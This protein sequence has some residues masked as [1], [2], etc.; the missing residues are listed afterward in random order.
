M[1]LAPVRFDRFELQP[2]ERRLLADGQPVPLGARAFDLLCL[3]ASRPGSLLTKAELLDAVWAGLVVEEANLTV[4]IS[5]LRKV[6]GSDCIATVPGRGYRFT[7]AP[8][9]AAAPPPAT[10]PAHP[11]EPPAGAPTAAQA[12][13]PAL[14]GRTADRRRLLQALAAPGCVT[15]CGLAGV[16]KTALAQSVA[17]GWPTGAVWVDLAALPGGDQLPSALARALGLPTPEPGDAAGLLA[18]LAG[19]LLVLDNAEHLVEAVAAQVA[20]LLAAAPAGALLVTSQ[21]PL[22]LPQERVLRLEPLAC[23]GGPGAAEARDADGALDLFLAR[24]RAADHRFAPGPD[25]LPLLHDICRRLDGLPLALELAAARV[26]ALGLQGLQRAL[27]G[28]F[29]VLTRGSRSAA[30]RHRTLQAALDWSHGLLQPA[31][32][33]LFRTLAVFSGGFTLDGVIAVAGG[34]GAE[35]WAVVDTLASLVERSLVAADGA[36]AP[37]YRLLE[38]PRAYAADRLAASGEEPAVRR[39]HAEALLEQYLRVGPGRSVTAAE[40]A[41]A[42]R[43]HDDVRD[44]IGWAQRHAP[45]VAVPLATAV[46]RLALFTSWRV[47]SVGWLEACAACIDDPAVDAVAR[48]LWWTELARQRLM[49]S[50]PD[51]AATAARAR[52]LARAADQPNALFNA[53]IVWARATLEPGPEMDAVLA[54]IQALHDAHVDRQ[55]SLSMPLHGTLALCAGHRRDYESELRHRRD[56][57]A[58]AR[59]ANNPDMVDAAETNIVA[60]L[61]NLGRYDEA[62]T[63][64]DLLLERLAGDTGS[65]RAYALAMRSA[66]LVR[67]GRHAEVRAGAR[68]L[69][70]ALERLRLPH[71]AVDWALMLA[72]EER[73]REAARV[74]GLLL[75]TSERGGEGL[76]RGARELFDT[77]RTRG[78]AALGEARWQ[79]EQD[80]GRSAPVD[81]V[82]GWIGAPAA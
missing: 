22:Q 10:S 1:L 21:L 57:L 71:L 50:R 12:V 37:R 39:R 20:A 82:F 27:E 81:A 43:E 70:A 60:T 75:Q 29:A 53:G 6:L 4:Q 15:L 51:A 26:P 61:H 64:V 41:A 28:R 65:N 5:A 34:D 36:D 55:P 18:A 8:V 32:Q 79:A 24:A 74:S 59:R 31:E 17:A 52:E 38:T 62:L 9:P 30:E 72:N 63:H 66:A 73:H 23:P 76:L 33:R 40:R 78:C 11:P 58:A 48:A 68:E 2:Q 49:S 3:L 47:E 19:R 69:W 56:E 13:G 77:V 67:L 7:A 35:R 80:H 46:S 16:G 54:E 14:Y 42:L 44:A 45:E 25:A